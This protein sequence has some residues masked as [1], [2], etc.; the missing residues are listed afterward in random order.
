MQEPP[1]LAQTNLIKA[2]PFNFPLRLFG[3]QLNDFNH[4]KIK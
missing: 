1:I 3:I 4:R 2:L